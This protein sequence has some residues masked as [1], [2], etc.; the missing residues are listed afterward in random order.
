MND[1]KDV[2]ISHA[3]PSDSGKY[4]CAIGDEGEL[5]NEFNLQVE[6]EF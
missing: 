5:S 2:V 4:S 1:L 6:R 3:A